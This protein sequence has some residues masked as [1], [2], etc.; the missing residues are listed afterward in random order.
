MTNEAGS[1]AGPSMVDP[2]N[3][4]A[5]TVSTQ[6]APPRAS[7]RLGRGCPM[8][9]QVAPRGDARSGGHRLLRRRPRSSLRWFPGAS[10]D[11][12]QV[13]RGLPMIRGDN[14]SLHPP[15]VGRY[16]PAALVAARGSRAGLRTPTF[17]G[18]SATLIRL[19]FV[20]QGVSPRSSSA[21]A[22]SIVTG[23]AIMGRGTPRG[24][25]STGFSHT[26]RRESGAERHL[27]VW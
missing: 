20:V 23:R 25:T 27:G 6:P 19:R 12:H 21:V 13:R 9:S 4:Q 26:P 17:P 14:D 2:R 11:D 16:P 15:H 5:A 22:R 1:S 8:A 10:A 18:E 7:S 3:R 24:W